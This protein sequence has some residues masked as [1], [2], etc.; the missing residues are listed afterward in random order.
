M[1]TWGELAEAMP[2]M[3]ERGVLIH[4]PRHPRPDDV[5]R[6]RVAQACGDDAEAG[7]VFELGIERAMHKGRE[8]G[9]G[10]AIYSKWHE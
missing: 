1:A 5:L 2:A 6:V 8:K 10:R 9:T 7:E 3:A 4:G